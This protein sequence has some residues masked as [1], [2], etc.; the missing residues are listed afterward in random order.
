MEQLPLIFKQDGSQTLPIFRN[1][2]WVCRVS[3]RTHR[4][5]QAR[6]TLIDNSVNIKDIKVT[7]DYRHYY[8]ETIARKII[9][10]PLVIEFGQPPFESGKFLIEKKDL[11]V[12]WVGSDDPNGSINQRGIIGLATVED[13]HL[14]GSGNSARCALRAE[15]IIQIENFLGNSSILESAYREESLIDDIKVFGL[16]Q[17]PQAHNFVRFF[18]K[19]DDTDK[20]VQRL[21]GL[22]GMFTEVD[23]HVKDKLLNSNYPELAALVPTPPPIDDTH[24]TLPD[25]SVNLSLPLTN[26]LCTKPFV[27]LTG[28]SGTGK[29]K[30]AIELASAFDYGSAI[31]PSLK[32]SQVRPATCLAYVPV[33]ADWTDQKNLLGYS[34]PFGSKRLVNGSETYLTYEVT[35][36]LRLVLRAMHPEYRYMPHFLVLDEMNLSHVERYFSSFLSLMEAARSTADSNSFELI[37]RN[38]L[39]LICEVLQAQGNSPMEVEAAKA[40]LEEQ[41]GL[42]FPANLFV[43]G[44]VNIDETTY[45]FSPKVLDRAFVMEMKSINPSIYLEEQ[46]VAVGSADSKMEMIAGVQAAELFRQSIKRRTQGSWERQKPVEILKAVATKTGVDA[47]TLDALI[48]GVNLTLSGS[49]QLLEPVGFGFGYRVVNEVCQYLAVWL[50]AKHLQTEGAESFASQ[51]SLALDDAVMMKVLPKLH[52]NRRQLGDSLKAL[53]DF[54]SQKVASYQI[55]SAEP[56]KIED[57]NKLNFSLPA[58]QQKA[59]QLYRLLQGSGYTTF[60]SS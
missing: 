3:P 8:Q 59:E 56:V 29:S 19:S 13:I 55:G 48:S 57:K 24:K 2:I 1:N 16:K 49:Y 58:S 47:E 41:Y 27:I 5:N 36:A 45:M 28:P 15:V 39:Q 43:I 21:R 38:D 54:F 22:L 46:E 51:W 12:L 30:I 11:L 10:N 53:A 14:E 4:R 35:E 31:P 7:D 6:G 44:T 40:L 42:P 25:I 32:K 26:A 17:S 23:P 34:N 60:I 20:K 37:S 52:G 50:E 33:G 18:L 9:P